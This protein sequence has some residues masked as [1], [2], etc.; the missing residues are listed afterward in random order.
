MISITAS[1]GFC[2]AFS[3]FTH[4]HREAGNDDSQFLRRLEADPADWRNLMDTIGG[5]TRDEESTSLP[6]PFHWREDIGKLKGLTGLRYKGFGTD[7]P[8]YVKAIVN[9]VTPPGFPRNVPSLPSYFV[10]PPIVDE[11]I[12]KLFH[13]VPGM[14]TKHVVVT[15][16]GGAGKTL[17]A[18]AVTR[19]KD[20]RRYFSDGILWMKDGRDSEN[21]DSSLLSRLEGLARQFQN[22]LVLRFYRQGRVFQHEDPHF[23]NV[24]DAQEYFRMWQEKNHTLKC[25]L[26]VDDV[27][28]LVSLESSLRQFIICYQFCRRKTTEWSTSR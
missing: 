2:E 14:N 7:E 3:Y 18:S 19:N 10:K 16:M 6:D 21:Y 12:S 11:L 22:H 8:S 20:I 5:S 15:G 4:L 23:K 24:Q 13:S 17:I 25:L 9:M 1:Q 27:W 26:I 28:N